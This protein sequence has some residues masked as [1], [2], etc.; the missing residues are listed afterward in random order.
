MQKP[1][2]ILNVPLFP[3]GPFQ[4]D[5]L[6]VPEG[7]LFDHIHN[8][9]RCWPFVRWNQTGA[10]ACQERGMQMRS[11]A[12]LLPCG[13]SLFSGVEFVCCP[14]HFKGSMKFILKSN[15][16]QLMSTINHKADTVRV[17]KID[18]PQILPEA[19]PSAYDDDSQS[20]DDDA[21]SDDILADEALDNNGDDGD[22]YYSDESDL[23]R[24]SDDSA[25]IRKAEA[26][27][28]QQMSNNAA[29]NA[30]TDL[31]S[32]ASTPPAKSES[33]LMKEAT[34]DPYFTHFDPRLEHQSYKVSILV[35]P[36]Y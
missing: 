21:T 26:E 36:D 28:A 35:I 10:A 20:V 4:S 31:P 5:A 32:A 23:D 2:A 27:N 3:E 15:I 13:I 25:E 30:V 7:C 17:K 11:F 14:K 6:L 24:D 34:V 16:V 18:L 19:M 12:M 1:N 8:A 29:D 33:P 9:S 22:E